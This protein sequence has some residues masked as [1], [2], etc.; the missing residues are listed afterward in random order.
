MSQARQRWQAPVPVRLAVFTTPFLVALYAV[1]RALDAEVREPALLIV[2]K[3][4]LFALLTFGVT[5]F[6]M[7][8]ALA[9]A[10]GRRRLGVW[11][12]LAILGGAAAILAYL[13]WV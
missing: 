10:V 6:A 5:R 12:A 4:A 3:S 7:G 8:P 11:E 2:A 1:G 13:A 9:R